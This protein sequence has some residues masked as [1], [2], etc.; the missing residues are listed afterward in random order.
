[1]L[2]VSMLAQPAGP[3]ESHTSTTRKMYSAC[4]LVVSPDVTHG[5][6]SPLR[7]TEANGYAAA[8]QKQGL[9][10]G[11]RIFSRCLSGIDIAAAWDVL[12]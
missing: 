5:G 4:F 9:I 6:G 12:R 10:F 2:E 1:M 3:R 7:G 11:T 8:L